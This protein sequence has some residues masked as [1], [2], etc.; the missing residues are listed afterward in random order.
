LLFIVLTFVAVGLV[1]V[2]RRLRVH[3]IQYALI[4][5][6]LALFLLLPVSL[7]KPVDFGVAYTIAATA[8][9]LLLGYYGAHALQGWRAGLAFAGGIGGLY[10]LLYLLLLSEPSLLVLGSV[11]LFAVLAAVMLVTR[12]I[13][14]YALGA[15]WRSEAENATKPLRP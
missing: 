12:R 11:L 7:G 2:L 5:S 3:P 1:E 8:C 4:G 9:T 10:G 15:R 14:S 13:D 6:A